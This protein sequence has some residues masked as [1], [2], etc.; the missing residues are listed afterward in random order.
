LFAFSFFS[1]FLTGGFYP[2]KK[3]LL[4]SRDGELEEEG[5]GEWRV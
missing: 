2:S 4:L 1:P 5:L 3:G